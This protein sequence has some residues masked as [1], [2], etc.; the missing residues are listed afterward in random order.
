[1][2]NDISDEEAIEHFK[3]RLRKLS[4][5]EQQRLKVVIGKRVYPVKDIL[6]HMM[7]RDEIGRIEI[8]IEKEYMRWL[9]ERRKR[10]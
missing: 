7:A 8:E 6:K 9:R 5:E 10:K 1:M 2:V 3:G 4:P